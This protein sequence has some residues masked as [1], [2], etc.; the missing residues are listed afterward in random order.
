MDKSEELK[1]TPTRVVWEEPGSRRSGNPKYTARFTAMK[2]NTGRWLLW[3]VGVDRHE[4]TRIRK[5]LSK[6]GYQVAARQMPGKKGTFKVYCRYYPYKTQSHKPTIE[7][8]TSVTGKGGGYY[9]R[10]PV[11]CVVCGKEVKGNA[12]L[13]QHER[14]HRNDVSVVNEEVQVSFPKVSL[15]PIVKHGTMAGYKT[16][17]RQGSKPCDA[18]RAWGYKY[19]SATRSGDKKEIARL[20]SACVPA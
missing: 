17:Q 5:M 18:C 19:K 11:K 7:T 10:V 20:R 14:S 9:P 15:S 16:H 6:D 4:A 12:A 1:L 13:R 3:A 8:S 2:K